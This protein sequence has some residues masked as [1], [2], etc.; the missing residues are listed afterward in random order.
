MTITNRIKAEALAIARTE[1][2]TAVRIRPPIWNLWLNFKC[3]S[4]SLARFSLCFGLSEGGLSHVGHLDPLRVRRGPLVVV[5]M[6]VPPLV[7]WSL[8][9]TVRQ[10]FPNL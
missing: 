7:R 9:V 4:D 1:N 6:P 5:V 3:K 10:V 2:S 8:G